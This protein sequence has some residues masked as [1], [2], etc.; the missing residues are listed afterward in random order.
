MSRTRKIQVL[1]IAVALSAELFLLSYAQTT[2]PFKPTEVQTLKLKVLQQQAQ[3][4]QRDMLDAQKRFS[5]ALTGLSTEADKVKKENNWPDTVQ[6][7]QNTLTYSLPPTPSEK[8][9]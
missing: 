5:D 2:G 6:F 1:I 4:A 3:L 9:P 8:K 7:D